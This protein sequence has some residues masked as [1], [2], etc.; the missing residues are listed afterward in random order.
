MRIIAGDMKGRVLHM[1]RRASFRPTTDRVKEALFNMLNG[2]LTWEHCRAC[3]LFA[4]SG[5]L[6]LEALSRGAHS[7][8]FV[9]QNRQHRLVLERNIEQFGVSDRTQVLPM[10]AEQF[11]AGGVS[12]FT[13]VFADPPYDY[14]HYTA[15]LS[16][17]ARLLRP[18]GIL[19]V[20]HAA[21]T[22]IPDAP[23]FRMHDRRNY[24]R[25]AITIF[26]FQAGEDAS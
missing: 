19:T 3:D 10:R 23:S 12:D 15:L 13:M 24:G 1:P 2:I 21:G 7:V 25:T 8:T 5:N 4:G 20:E 17:C 16:G 26:R 18:D 11:W 14:A 6:G 22:E 9:E